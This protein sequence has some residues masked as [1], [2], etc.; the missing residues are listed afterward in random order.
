VWVDLRLSRQVFGLLPTFIMPGNPYKYPKRVTRPKV[1]K[2]SPTTGQAQMNF[3]DTSNYPYPVT[4]FE[5][6]SLEF[7]ISDMW[8]GVIAW[9]AEFAKWSNVDVAA[10]ALA[11]LQEE[12]GIVLDATILHGDET[13]TTSNI[14]HYGT[15]PS[16][17]DYNYVLL[18]D[19]LRHMAIGNSLVNDFGGAGFVHQDIVTLK[20]KLGVMGV[21]P[22]G[23]FFIVD[24]N[25]QFAM[26][27]MDE[28]VTVDKYGPQATIHTGEIGRLH[29]VPIIVSQEMELVNASGQIEDSHDSTQSSGLLWRPALY[30]FGIDWDRMFVRERMPGLDDEWIRFKAS[31]DM[32]EFQDGVAYGYDWS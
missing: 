25:L 9:Q 24:Y 7:A 30:K 23:L 13:A 27:I 8:G 29:G 31:G 2:V 32:Q 19:G 1:K 12:A 5:T 4:K 26:E 22:N 11:A 10:E 18:M 17:T 21:D 28:V 14:S 20:K 3:A 15:D 6:D 16:S